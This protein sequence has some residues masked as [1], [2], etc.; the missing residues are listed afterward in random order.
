MQEQPET[1][2]VTSIDH[3]IAILSSW[4]GEKVKLLEH[5]LEVPEGTEVNYNGEGDL[6]LTGD[7]RKGF[8]IGLSLALMELGTLPFGCEYEE[9]GQAGEVAT[10]H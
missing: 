2:E 6:P 3:F 8:I 5:M 4:H 1:I 9:E 7:L 10:T